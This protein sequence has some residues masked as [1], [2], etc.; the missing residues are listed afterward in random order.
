[1]RIKIKPQL[2]VMDKEVQTED[3]DHQLKLNNSPTLYTKCL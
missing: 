1:M 3:L 2:H